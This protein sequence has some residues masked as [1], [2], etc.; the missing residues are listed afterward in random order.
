VAARV[1]AQGRGA[2]A[3]LRLRRGRGALD[4]LRLGGWIADL[5]HHARHDAGDQHGGDGEEDD[6]FHQV[7]ATDLPATQAW[8]RQQTR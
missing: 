7:T 5:A 2:I 6:L 1:G 3:A 8:R 4:R